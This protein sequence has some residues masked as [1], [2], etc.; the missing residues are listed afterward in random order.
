[1][2]EDTV[3][4]IEIHASQET[5]FAGLNDRLLTP[6]SGFLIATVMH[7]GLL[8]IMTFIVIL[9]V[10]VVMKL[11]MRSNWRDFFKIMRALIFESPRKPVKN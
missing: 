10:E 3:A 5:T 9:V 7:F 2:S 6:A 4:R 1:M 11:I 8:S